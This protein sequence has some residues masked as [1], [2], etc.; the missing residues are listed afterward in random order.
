[1]SPLET[2]LR[3]RIDALLD[4]RERLRADLERARRSRDR[5]GKSLYE[6]RLARDRWRQRYSALWAMS[7]ARRDC[8]CSSG[9]RLVVVCD[10]CGKRRGVK[11]AAA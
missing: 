6:A 11:G 1:M 8:E 3:V 2:R 10:S 7:G 9:A 4:E 5:H